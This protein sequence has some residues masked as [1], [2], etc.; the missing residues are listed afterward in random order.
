MLLSVLCIMPLPSPPLFDFPKHTATTPS[1]EH[2]VCFWH[3]VVVHCWYHHHRT[4]I[5]TCLSE[6]TLLDG[7]TSYAVEH[8]VL[9]IHMCC[10]RCTTASRNTARGARPPIVCGTPLGPFGFVQTGVRGGEDDPAHI[11]DVVFC[12]FTGMQYSSK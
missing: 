5:R 2:M 10:F 4:M 6:Q 7:L 11:E 12:I 3:R 1:A 9:D 8:C